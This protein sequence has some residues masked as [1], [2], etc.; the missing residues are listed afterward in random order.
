[1][2]ARLQ[3]GLIVSI[4]LVALAW[5]AFA[6]SLGYPWLALAGAA[7]VLLG[8]ALVLAV[9]FVLLACVHRDDPTP[10]ASPSQLLRA[11]FG[12]CV[13]AARVFGWWQPF[14]SEALPD[15]PGRP[16]VRGIV[17]VH[18]YLCNRGLWI[19][20]LK[21]CAAAR[22]PCIAV[23]LEPV[24][25]ELDAYVPAIEQAVSKLHRETGLAPLLVCHSMGGLVGRAWLAATP[26]ADARVHR[27]FTIGTP[28]QGT[29]LARLSR[30]AN[31]QHMRQSCEWLRRLAQGEPAGR[32]AGFTCFYGHADNIVMP[33]AA[34][35]L[36]GSVACHVSATA[37][38]AMAFHPE[39]IREVWRWLDVPA[40]SRPAV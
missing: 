25:S 28:H 24:F 23:S 27:V 16:G 36:P 19:P 6:W 37:H 21:R 29:W 2:L 14:R 15:V 18:G 9:E 10:R 7:F 20:W 33:P 35:I 32:A 13:I 22:Q 26:G 39:V 11:W 40:A 4:G 1:M 31:A 12:E 17:F 8:Y 5:F 34:A 38:V 3:R 30:T